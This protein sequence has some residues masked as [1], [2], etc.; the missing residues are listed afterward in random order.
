MHRGSRCSY[1]KQQQVPPRAVP[2][3]G[4]T[5]FWMFRACRTPSQPPPARC[6]R[7]G[8]ERRGFQHPNGWSGREAGD[9][10]AAVSIAIVLRFVAVD[11]LGCE[12]HR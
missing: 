6:A 5:V 11:A 12:N 10:K 7:G 1:R 2:V 8:A 9:L 4:M 3:F